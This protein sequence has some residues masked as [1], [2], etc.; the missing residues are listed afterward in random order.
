VVESE[1]IVDN[2]RI[3]HHTLSEDLPTETLDVDGLIEDA[4]KDV[5]WPQ[6]KNVNIR[7][8]PEMGRMVNGSVVL[9]DVFYTLIN[10][11]IMCSRGD[12]TLDV[13]VDK[14]HIDMQPYYA[15]S[16]IDNSQQIPDETRDELFTFHLGITQA[17][18]RA[19]PMFLVRLIVDRLGG[20]IRVESRV[21]GDYKQGTEFVITLPAIEAKVVPETEPAY[22]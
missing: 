16:I 21:P 8:T 11:A 18:G 7:Y 10:N 19:L 14:V 6:T 5:G 20:D 3:L 17:H 15:V 9:K 22:R 2:V 13:N 4:I 12:V 1:T